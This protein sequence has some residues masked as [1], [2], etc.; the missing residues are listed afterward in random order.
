MTVV[1]GGYFCG[2]NAAL[3]GFTRMRPRT[4][5]PD[6]HSHCRSGQLAYRFPVSTVLTLEIPE[7]AHQILGTRPEDIARDVWET[8]VV[9]WF[10]EGRL[11]QGQAAEMLTL[12]RG[13]FFDV[14]ERHHVSP[15]QM[16]SEELEKDFQGA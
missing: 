15:I 11:S 14:L 16:S 2:V 1:A 6:I 3:R 13:E 9:K 12:P 10:D 7:S 8:A 4:G 5:M